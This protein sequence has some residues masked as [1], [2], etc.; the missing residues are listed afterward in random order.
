ME[1]I[2]QN[3]LLQYT[4]ESIPNKIDYI[5]EIEILIYDLVEKRYNDFKTL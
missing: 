1:Y 5:V 4:K 3:G 2:K